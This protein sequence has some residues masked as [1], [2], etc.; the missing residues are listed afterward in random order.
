LRKP[1]GTK[2]PFLEGEK[3]RSE[4]YVDIGA[5]GI[6]QAVLDK[7]PFDA[8]ATGRKVEE[9]VAKVKGF[10]MLYVQAGQQLRAGRSAAPPSHPL[11]SPRRYADSYMTKDEFRSMFDHVHYDKMKSK[12][13]ARGAFPEVYAKVC[14]K[15]QALWGKGGEKVAEEG[16]KKK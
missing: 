14:K 3:L 1:E 12:Y 16:K 15:G 7:K 9:Y 6:P 10:Q 11:A 13:D 8:V 4:M 2:K 5:Y